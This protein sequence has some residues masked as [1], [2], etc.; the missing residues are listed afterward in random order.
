MDNDGETTAQPIRAFD[1]EMNTIFVGVDGSVQ[2]VSYDSNDRFNIDFPDPDGDGPATDPDDAPYSYGA[3][4]KALSKA[5]GY[6]LTWTYV[7]RGSRATNTFNLVV[8]APA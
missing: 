6:T 7:G 8:P 2:F 4:E 3:F 5:E 1:T